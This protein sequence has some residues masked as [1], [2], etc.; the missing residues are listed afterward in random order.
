MEYDHEKLDEITM[1]LLC[2]GIHDETSFGARAWKG[3][4]WDSLNRL[5]ERGLIGDPRS[6][7]KS[8]TMSP[9]SVER[10]RE[11]FQRHFALDP[12][13]STGENSLPST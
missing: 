12:N 1:A 6:R 10:A 2:L 9:E 5:H 7:A 3:L 11:L 13:S 4:D 8:V